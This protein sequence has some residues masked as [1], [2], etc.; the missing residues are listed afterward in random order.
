MS[1]SRSCCR[2]GE[3]GRRCRHSLGPLLALGLGN[4]RVWHPVGPWV[5][6]RVEVPRTAQ[7]FGTEALGHPAHHVRDVTKLCGFD[8]D[9]LGAQAFEFPGRFR[10]SHRVERSSCH[11]KAIGPRSRVR[12][13]SERRFASARS[14]ALS[15]GRET[16]RGRTFD[17]AGKQSGRS[18]GRGTLATYPD[19]LPG[20]GSPDAQ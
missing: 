6:D 13:T 18:S 4:V 19:D 2:A 16:S 11:A 5:S 1:S 14:P 20:A 12:K 9:A 8:E 17:A 7:F 15:G 10:A 3:Q